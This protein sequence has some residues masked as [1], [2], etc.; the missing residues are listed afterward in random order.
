MNTDEV[1]G[2]GGTTA[3]VRKTQRKGRA[4]VEVRNDSGLNG[5][6]HDIIGA[7]I[8]VHRE[9][10]PGHDE[11]AYEEALG[12]QLTTEGLR[13]RVQVPLPLRYKGFKLDCGYR[14]DLLVEERVVVE[15]KSV[16]TVAPIHDAQ[17]LTYLRLGQWPVGLLINFNEV[18][19]RD[20][21]HR[22][23]MD[24]LEEGE[25]TTAEARKTQRGAESV[26][27][28][29]KYDDRLEAAAAMGNGGDGRWTGLFLGAAIEVHRT[30]GPGL[31]PSAY[32]ACLAHEMA[33]RDLPFRRSQPVALN[34]RG[35]GLRG[36]SVMDFVVADELVVKLLTVDSIRSLHEGQIRS[37]LKFSGHPLGLIINFNTTALSNGIRRIIYTQR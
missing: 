27:G 30:L 14:L 26:P 8:A 13:F 3:E 16:D 33:L 6:T 18:V 25:G 36:G 20:G 29:R 9:L 10:G 12:E 22:R 1:Q 23:V 7:A 15:V 21:I 11:A 35:H 19:V 28:P 31:L 34:H 24:F 5:I 2:E 32:A 37:Q 4:T 17:L